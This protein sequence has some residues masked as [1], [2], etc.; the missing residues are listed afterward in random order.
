M[1]VTVGLEDEQDLLPL[2][3]S[4]LDQDMKSMLLVVSKINRMGRVS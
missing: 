1:G 2:A 4:H 3:A